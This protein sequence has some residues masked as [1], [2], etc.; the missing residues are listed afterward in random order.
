MSFQNVSDVSACLHLVQ[1]STKAKGAWLEP[2]SEAI[3]MSLRSN[4]QNVQNRAALDP[5]DHVDF[6]DVSDTEIPRLAALI[7]SLAVNVV[8][9]ALLLRSCLQKSRSFSNGA[10]FAMP[11]RYPFLSSYFGGC[12]K[13][14]TCTTIL[15]RF[16][17]LWSSNLENPCLRLSCNGLSIESR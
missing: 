7:T 12:C 10:L 1:S 5:F 11:C 15:N 13:G 9:T 3:S 4:L 6:A 16:E 2:P 14:Y 8:L 17:D